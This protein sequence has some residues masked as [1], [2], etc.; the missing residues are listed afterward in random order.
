MN[1]DRTPTGELDAAVPGSPI[2]PLGRLHNYRIAEGDPDVRGW[3][4]LG[5][6]SRKIGEVDDLLVD[7]QALRVRYLDVILDPDLFAERGPAVGQAGETAAPLAGPAA[8]A[9]GTLA[10]P[11]MPPYGAP[12]SATSA[13]GG[14]APMVTETVVRATLSDEENRL[15]QEHNYGFG[16]RHV[17]IPIGH[18]RLDGERDRILVEGL[19]AAEAAGLPDYDGE[20]VT[21]DYE[22]G[23]R[24]RFDRGYAPSPERD[25]Y[26]HDLYDQERF[27]GPRRHRADR[28]QTVAD[29]ARAAGLEPGGAAP[30]GELDRTVTGE[31]DRVV[32]APDHSQLRDEAGA[33]QEEAALPVRGRS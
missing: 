10:A 28:G 14:L 32:G 19:R 33:P 5:A 6:D 1:D 24:Q 21:R 16:T 12:L 30:A 25:F 9:E 18:A 27:Y 2:T 13:M 11:G 17:L 20:D 26:A 15:T 7:T 3:E 4:V 29:N 8:G 23:L 22:T 31:L